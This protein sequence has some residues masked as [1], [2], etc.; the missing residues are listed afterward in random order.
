M[1]DTTTSFLETVIAGQAR[2]I[3]TGVA[4]GLVA[5]GAL[6]A[7]QSNSFVQIGA[8]LVLYGI[9]AGWSWWQKNGQALVKARLDKLRHRVAAIPIVT[10]T[11]PTIAVNSAIIKAKEMAVVDT[12]ANPVLPVTGDQRL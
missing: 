5:H 2:H 8:G 3:L 7:D 4:G 6:T 1:D 11:T 9:G 12:V 10:A